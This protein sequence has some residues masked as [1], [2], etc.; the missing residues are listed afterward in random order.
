MGIDLRLLNEAELSDVR[1]QLE[2]IQNR[3]DDAGFRF[4]E[5]EL[6]WLQQAI[7]QRLPR[8]QRIDAGETAAIAR[9]LEH[10][11]TKTYDK[12]YAE[13]KA[14]RFVPVDTS[15]PSD[16]EFYTYL[17]WNM[18]GMAD[19]IA[20]FADNFTRVDVHVEETIAKIK[21]FGAAYGFSILDMRRSARTGSQLETKKA[22]AAR[23]AHEQRFDETVA[24]GNV[25]AGLNGFLNNANVP[26]VAPTTGTWV[27]LNATPLQMIQDLNDLV[28]SIILATLEIFVPDTLLLDNVSFERLNTTPMSTTGD[29]DKTV[30]RFFLDNNPYITDIDQWNKLNTAGAGGVSRAVAYKRDEEVLAAVEPQ[31]F[32]QLPPQERNMEF[33]INTHTRNGGVRIQYPLAIAYMDDLSG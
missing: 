13:L 25:A 4:D 22:M 23:R 3:F 26:I 19:L 8:E 9:Q 17:S 32:E 7:N 30:L 27:T 2:A 1:R 29:A 21:S 20:N 24:L 11:Y 33:V 15:V 5:Q 28:N 31:P 10:I 6:V 18:F 14:R 12:K 16:A